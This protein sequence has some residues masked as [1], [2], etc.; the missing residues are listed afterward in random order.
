MS[1]GFLVVAGILEVFFAYCLKASESFTRIAPTVSFVLGVVVSLYCLS[2]ALQTIPLGT[3]YAVWTG[4]GAVG[5]VILGI[6]IY[7]DPVSLGRIFFMATL[8]LS[9]VGLK[10]F[11][12]TV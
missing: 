9:I 6:A 7:G 1:W 2:R 11:G 4:I 8:I 12:G 3:A 10:F 5:T